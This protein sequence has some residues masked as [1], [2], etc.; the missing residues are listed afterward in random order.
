MN[1]KFYQ[2]SEEK[3]LKIINAGLNVF[4]NNEY[5]KASTEEIA[6][7]AGIS[8]G[9]LFYYFHNKKEFYHFLYDYLVEWLTKDV[10]DE[11]YKT[12][13]DFF[14]LLEYAAKKKYT[15][16]LKYPDIMK[17][18]VKYFYS[19]DENVSQESNKKIFEFDSNIIS[20]YFNH[21]DLSKFR[22]DV[23]PQKIF[24]ILLYMGDGYLNYIQMSGQEINIDKV[25]NEYLGYME[26][27]RKVA[28]KEEFQ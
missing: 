27:I 7:K 1:D 10:V 16:M 17:F 13:T 19:K 21:I 9:L 5:K 2:L 3:R 18:A 6:E 25:M 14:E 24:E 8:K 22:E 15:V 26:L 11:K 12:I 20:N 28:Y 4:G 23:D